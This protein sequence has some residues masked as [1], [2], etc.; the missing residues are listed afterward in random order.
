MFINFGVSSILVFALGT[1]GDWIG[2]ERTYQICVVFAL[3]MIP[4]A[5]LTTK[6]NRAEKTP[7]P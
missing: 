1:V 5:F 4:M 2:L 6:F 3:G 7:A